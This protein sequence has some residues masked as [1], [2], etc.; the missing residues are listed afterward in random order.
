MGIS[1]STAD[2][3]FMYTNGSIR[4]SVICSGVAGVLGG[5]P[6]V[7]AALPRVLGAR[8]RRPGGIRGASRRARGENLAWRLASE[9]L[10]PHVNA[11]CILCGC[12]GFHGSARSAGPTFLDPLQNA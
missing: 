3:F 2:D 9:D 7:L 8:A 5:L 12:G 1:V 6:G 4:V 10:T 11:A